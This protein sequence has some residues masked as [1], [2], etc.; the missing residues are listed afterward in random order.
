MYNRQYLNIINSVDISINE[1]T[2]K[3]MSISPMDLL[4][5]KDEVLIEAN[6]NMGNIK[7][8]YDKIL[9]RVK[10]LN[11][12]FIKIARDMVKKNE[13]WLNDAKSYHLDINK[14][15]EFKYEMFPYWNGIRL[16]A[17]IE[18]PKYNKEMN[19]YLSNSD[20]QG[21]YKT[22]YKSLEFL[23]DGSLNQN[24]LRG[25]DKKIIVNSGLVSQTYN[26]CIKIIE[27]YKSLSEK[28]Y[29]ENIELLRTLEMAKNG[30][31]ITESIAFDQSVFKSQ[32]TNMLYDTLLEADENTNIKAETPDSIKKDIEK[33]KKP[34]ITVNKDENEKF[35][36]K[37]DTSNV[38]KNYFDFCYKINT[39]LM[40]LL[41][42]SY[43]ESVKFI[44]SVRK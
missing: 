15:K 14:L 24:K 21:F 12:K 28:I 11:I 7:N 38:I 1:S 9:L 8:Q 4:N 33:E 13:A 43:K 39:V 29:A 10:E 2:L 5:N 31:I 41:E 6:I 32:L 17:Q 34:E 35:K 42:E 26:N 37:K 44:D 19:Q 25:S 20:Q 27:G 30:S 22:Y 40:S 16:L 36:E 3:L 23:E 18:V